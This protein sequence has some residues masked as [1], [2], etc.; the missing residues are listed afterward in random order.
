MLIGAGVINLSLSSSPES[1]GILS[2]FPKWA[3]PLVPLYE[4]LLGG[5]LVSGW[6]RYGAWVA[7]LVTLFIFSLHNFA[8]MSAGRSSCGCMGPVVDV[9]PGVMLAFDVCAGM[10]FLKRRPG[11]AGWPTTTDNPWL[12][13]LVTTAGVMVA[14]LGTAATFAYLNY[15]SVTA[16]VADL[17]DESLAVVPTDLELGEVDHG[18][19]VE[20]SVRVHNLTDEP[21][22]LAYAK[23]SCACAVFPDLP[24]VVPPRGTAYVRVLVTVTGRPGRFLRDGIFRTNVGHVRFGIQ[25]WVSGSQ[26]NRP[27]NPQ[28]S[29][30]P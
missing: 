9:S 19:V 4:L 7:S 5:W 26:V 25:G 2:L 10:V 27:I 16:A 13:P 29:I 30:S 1:T 12:R 8:L 15:G 23:G 24:L 28:G 20:T 11:W 21:A 18:T 3:L 6:L 17:R 22:H 14:V